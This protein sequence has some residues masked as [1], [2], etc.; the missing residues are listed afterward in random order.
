M[1]FLG[2]FPGDPAG[3]AITCSGNHLLEMPDVPVSKI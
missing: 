2:Q 3:Q 1:T